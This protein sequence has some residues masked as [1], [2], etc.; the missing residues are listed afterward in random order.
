M[1]TYL[2]IKLTVKDREVE[3][4]GWNMASSFKIH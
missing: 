2:R 4:D 1:V 3:G